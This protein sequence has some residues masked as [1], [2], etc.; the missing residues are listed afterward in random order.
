M[1][2]SY[3]FFIAFR[4]LTSKKRH[5]S[6]SFNT[7]ISI[8][9]VA[10]GVMALLIV[11]SVMSGYS[12]TLREKI[13]GINA[14]VII[15]NPF[16]K[17]RDY[18]KVVKKI[19]AVDGVEAA[20]PFLIGQTMLSHEDSAQGIYIRGVDTRYER[21][22]T[23]IHV[24]MKKGN[25]EDIDSREDIPGILLG[26][27]IA[28]KLNVQ[29]NDIITA[30]SPSGNKGFLSISSSTKRFKVAGIFE[31]GMYEFDSTLAVA[32]L[33]AIQDFMGVQDSVN[34]IQVRLIDPYSAR[35]AKEAILD[36]LPQEFY[37]RDWMEMNKNLFAA[38]KLQKTVLF[39]ILT[40]II[41]VASFT[42]ISTLLM[43][44]VEKE[45]EIAI[46]KAMGATNRDI[47]SLFTIQGLLIGLVGTVI[48]L[49]GGYLTGYLANTYELI[50]IPA[51]IYYLGHLTT[52][53]KLIDFIAVCTSALIISFLATIYPA[54]KASRAD[55][56][57]ILRY[58]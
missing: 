9:G 15:Y 10:I 28:Q 11:L 53:M 38:L 30:L 13:L 19:L 43:S 55:P 58:E 44:V 12:E 25:F 50:K 27:E 17:M 36:K 26:S 57:N 18:Q 40:L 49:G 1:K 48:G 20:S 41:L 4:H 46:L 54:W 32:S 37:A 33:S 22:T 8:T 42:I 31:T 14:H 29:L 21:E 47:M 7:G 24:F 16:G 2:R 35:G 5:G 6:L 3:T 52:R 39:V 45:R 23:Q 51:D 34:A 56:G